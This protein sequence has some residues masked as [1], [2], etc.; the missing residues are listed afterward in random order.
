M[1]INSYSFVNTKK[2]QGEVDTLLLYHFREEIFR[3]HD[4]NKVAREYYNNY[5]ILW[6]YTSTI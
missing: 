3:R 6:E 5:D 1:W 4:P 2:D